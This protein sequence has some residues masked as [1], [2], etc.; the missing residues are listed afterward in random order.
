[1]STFWIIV[2]IIFLLFTDVG[3]AVLGALVSCAL[4][5]AA[6]YAMFFFCV[7]IMAFAS[8]SL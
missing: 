3:N 4:V 5:A 7:A 8:G 1:M 6:L 2:A